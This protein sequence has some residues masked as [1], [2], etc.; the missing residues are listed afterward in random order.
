MACVGTV[1]ADNDAK[2]EKNRGRVSVEQT[3]AS[4]HLWEFTLAY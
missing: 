2:S 4:E 1:L 3:A